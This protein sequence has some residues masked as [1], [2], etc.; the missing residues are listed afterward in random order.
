ME[1]SLWWSGPEWPQT[2]SILAGKECFNHA[3]ESWGEA[4]KCQRNASTNLPYKIPKIFNCK[5]FD[6]NLG[7]RKSSTSTY[8]TFKK[9]TMRPLDRSRNSGSTL[10]NSERR[11]GRKFRPRNSRHCFKRSSSKIKP[12]EQPH[13]LRG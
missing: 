3:D 6:Q 11:T 1:S 8:E 13:A 10:R 9:G 5:T 2:S 12:I 4:S 7:F